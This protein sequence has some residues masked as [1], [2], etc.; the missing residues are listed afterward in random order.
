VLLPMSPRGSFSF[1]PPQIN[2]LPFV[3]NIKDILTIFILL[4]LLFPPSPCLPP[5]PPTYLVPLCFQNHF[6]FLHE[7]GYVIFWDYNT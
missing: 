7:N 2:T 4:L 5:A 1:K 3:L 6:L